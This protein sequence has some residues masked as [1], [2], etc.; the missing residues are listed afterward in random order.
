MRNL[1]FI[2]LIL[3]TGGVA[4]GQQTNEKLANQYYS[5]GEYEKAA[6]LYMNLWEK[7]KNRT[8]YYDRFF[9]CLLQ[10]DQYEAA[11]KDIDKRIKAEPKNPSLLIKKA[12][13][14]IATGASDQADAIY[15]EAIE[16]LTPDGAMIARLGQEFQ[17]IRNYDM[18]IETYEK[19]A[20]LI[21]DTVRFAN[22]LRALSDYAQDKDRLIKYCLLSVLQNKKNAVHVKRQLQRNLTPENHEQ[23][24][25]KLYVFIQNHPDR[26]VFTE[27]LEW[28]LVQLKD[29]PAALRQARAL[30]RKLEENGQRIFKLGQIAANHEDYKTAIEAYKYIIRKK[31]KNNSFYL[32]AKSEL[33]KT[34]RSLIVQGNG[35][36][37]TLD[38][39]EAEYLSFLDVYGRTANSAYVIL[40]LARFQNRY[41]K[42][43]EKAV[44]TLE[45]LVQMPGVNKQVLANAKLELGD[46]FLLKG[47]RWEATLL[48]AQVDKD[49]PEEHLGEV[50]R[51]RNA[52]LSYYVGDF[53]W[54]QAQFDIL[55]SSTTKL[56]A[57]DAID[58]SVF[59]MDNLGL[60]TTA[61]PLM[62]YADAELKIF[63]R[64]YEEAFEQLTILM[65]IYD[66]HGLQDDILYLRA[67]AHMDLEQYEDAAYL[68]ARVASDFP[69]DIRAD[70]SIYALAQLNEN[71]FDDLNQAANLYEKLFIDYHDS[72][73]AIDARKKYREL[74]KV[75]PEDE[76]IE[77]DLS[78][79]ELFMRGMKLN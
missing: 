45:E 70:N 78:P 43:S 72:T 67:N 8:H 33:L 14:L 4:M 66:G 71:V 6:V 10:S 53:E 35:G 55:K 21:R 22:Q 50:A 15:E 18:A 36:Q 28:S 63:Q 37:T 20:V 31:S 61:H 76:R 39:L 23:L 44:N 69:E 52:L 57:N 40:D 77:S 60:D 54:A 51:Y 38:S 7:S 56:I 58:R 29:F 11:H 62:V 49:F 48:Y 32:S 47:D 2:V 26:I 24:Q 3:F 1:I 9:T 79:E 46:L 65:N 13:I 75:I 34:K 68:Y 64:R 59:I 42:D 41:L 30:D 12:S 19:G 17:K 5:T 16:R 25:E 73:F 74:I 27:F